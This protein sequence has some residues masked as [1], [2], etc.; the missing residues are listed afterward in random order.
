M[1]QSNTIEQSKDGA[2]PRTPQAVFDRVA[3]YYDALNSV[4]SLGIDRRWR[5]HAIRSLGLQPG[6]RVLDVATGTGALAAEIVRATSGAVFVTGCDLNERM[7]SVARERAARARSHVD[8]VHCDAQSLP[9]D[10]GSFDAVT[11]GFAIDDMLDRPACMRE[12]WRVL[13][14]G[15][16]LALLELGQP[17]AQ[18]AKAAYQAY[19]KT[20]R[21]LG[22]GYRHLEQEILKYRGADSIRALLNDAGFSGYARESLTWGIARLHTAAKP[23]PVSR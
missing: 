21:L 2:R 12:I 16:R 11:I 6:A 3:P 10:T 19:L 4:L 23:S 14:S 20:F 13:R 18:P 9:F 1:K 15:G 7:L 17:D 22:R 5:R 8:F